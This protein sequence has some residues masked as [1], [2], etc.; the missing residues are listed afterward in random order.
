MRADATHDPLSRRFERLQARLLETDK[1]IVWLRAIAGAG[2]TRLLRAMLRGPHASV[3][4]RWA[5]FDGE[6]LE[7]VGDEL[8]DRTTLQGAEQPKVI[9]VTRPGGPLEPLFAKPNAY[10]LLETIT[11]DDLFLTSSDCDSI[12][13]RGLFDATGGWPMLVDALLQGRG[14]STR[15]VLPDFLEREVLPRLPREAMT[16]MLGA[17]CQPLQ[18]AAL[19]QLYGAQLVHPLLRSSPDG[20]LVAGSWV[21]DAL[22]RLLRRA[23]FGRRSVMD[24]LNQLYAAAADPVRAIQ[25]LV[26]IGRQDQALDVFERAGGMYFGYRHGF[27]ALEAVLHSIGQ[28][29]WRRRESLTLAHLWLLIKKGRS[30]EARRRLETVYPGM[31]VDLREEC[32]IASPYGALLRIAIASDAADGPPL[33]VIES[34]S[35]V[36][37]LFPAEDSMARGLLYNTMAIEFLRAGALRPAQELAQESL[38][39]YRKAGSSYLVHCMLLHLSDIAVRNCRLGEAEAF[40]QSAEQALQE[41]TLAFNTE[42]LI[43]A[44]C[45]A[46]IAYEQGRFEDFPAEVEATLQTLLEGDSWPDL[47]A[48]MAAHAVFSTFW[49]NGLPA[50]LDLLEH[51]SLTLSRRH[52]VA[53]QLSFGLIRIRLSQVAGRHEQANSQLQEIDSSPPLRMPPQTANEL[54]LARLRQRIARRQ[55]AEETLRTADALA[56]APYLSP[57]QK[58]ALSL[59]QAFLHHRGRRYGVAR[60]HLTVA[61]RAA[62]H[63]QLI[64][65][66]FE[67]AQIL[68]VLLPK[69]IDEPHTGEARLGVFARRVL[70]RLQALRSGPG[71]AKRVAGVSRQEHRV[72]SY[73]ADGNTNKQ[74]ARAMGLSQSAVKFHLRSLF[75]KLQVTSRLELLQAVQER[76][77]AT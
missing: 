34:W 22:L 9:V 20:V 55:G 38:A 57:R 24:D 17:V 36:A 54:V 43:V 70:H 51:C 65:V 16:G 60:R 3:F 13:C 15:E 67:E 73:L 7:G 6:Y 77:V 46:R 41:S 8:A 14:E 49:R 63:G 69:L 48:T 32:Q 64:G 26:E 52:G 50:A 31:S 27:H 75:R 18:Q 45:K 72:L 2:K 42:H 5:V 62:E 25:S 11:D 44:A 12:P 21:K 68:E 53:Q 28:E 76:G 4:S 30:V 10:G 39:A 61:L 33:E 66:L 35:R 58:I 1:P 19:E 29:R 59:L 74:I 40:L 37:E 23:S 56:D 71:H 47:I